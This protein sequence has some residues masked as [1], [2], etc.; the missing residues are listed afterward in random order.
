M[1]RASGV[2]LPVFS[3]PGRF[4][5]GTL[6]EEAYR[7]IDAMAD[8]GFSVWQ[9][10]PLT[11][12]DAY[13]SPYASDSS[14]AMDPT[15]LD[16]DTLVGEGAL[17]REEAEGGDHNALAALAAGRADRTALDGY[18][19]ANPEVAAY[20]RHRAENDATLY[21]HAFIQATV[22]RQWGALRDYAHSRG[23]R[24]I[25]D[26]PIYVAPG[27]ADA[28][29]Y[30]EAFLGEGDVAGVPPDYFA[31]EGQVWGNPLYDWER[32]R[33]GGYAFFRARLSYLLSRVDGVRLD[34]FRGFSA[35]YRIPGS[36]PA[37]AGHWEPGPGNSLFSAV[38]DLLAGREV[39]AEDLGEIDDA[40]VALRR[41]CGFLSSRVLQFGFLGDPASIHLPH[42]YTEDC[43]AY[44]GTHDNDTLQGYLL[45]MPE[46]ERAYLLD[47]CGATSL[48][49]AV[50][51]AVRTVLASVARL[52]V[53]PM[54]DLLG[55]GQEGRINT[56]GR[57]EG[58]W[59]WRL[60]AEWPD[61]F[62]RERYLYLNCLFGR[63]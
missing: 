48:E 40:V 59:S 24:I 36:A 41:G 46:S 27:S 10:L 57:A 14:F 5:R 7:F 30:P 23:V 39:I 33:E 47:Y 60:P 25:G 37:T 26:L 50:P 49:G 31:P 21:I 13:G 44:T 52:A 8:G 16:I 62:D 63:K 12:P 34:H 2:L 55:I 6:G 3:L 32:L 17:S 43:V 22:D 58:N 4:S 35:Y 61:V 11:P 56:P 38:S 18:L 54:Q 51:S 53:F 45:S 20:C 19:E 42:N 28:V 9:I 29:L 15:L 1:A